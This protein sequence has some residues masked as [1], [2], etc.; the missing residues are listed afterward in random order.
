MRKEGGMPKEYIR[1]DDFTPD[2][3]TNDARI[4][5]GRLEEGGEVQMAIFR[6]DG[7]YKSE[8][9]DPQYM[10]LNRYAINQM[11]KVLRRARDQAHG[12]D[13]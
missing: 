11:I 12:R 5:W 10:T 8:Y 13:E 3:H 9:E 1:G 4:S 2:D 7:T 6:N